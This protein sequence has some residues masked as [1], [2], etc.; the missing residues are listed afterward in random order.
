MVKRDNKYKLLADDSDFVDKFAVA[1]NESEMEVGGEETAMDLGMPGLPHPFGVVCQ[2]I[3]LT[4]KN[5]VERKRNKISFQRE[6][7]CCSLYFRDILLRLY[8]RGVCK[9]PRTRP[10]ETGLLFT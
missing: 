10:S 2:L 8:L 5:F 4:R 6:N 1:G 3:F 7:V 9:T